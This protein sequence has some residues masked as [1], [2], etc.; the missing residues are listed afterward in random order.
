VVLSQGQTATRLV[1]LVWDGESAADLGALDAEA[2]S[3]AISQRSEEMALWLSG[4][5][6]AEAVLTE[7]GWRRRPLDGVSII[8]KH[9]ED[10]AMHPLKGYYYTMAD[11][12]WF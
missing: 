9:S 8:I 11:A 5:V 4:D 10:M 3:F 2:A 12:D 1:D 6:A 7:L